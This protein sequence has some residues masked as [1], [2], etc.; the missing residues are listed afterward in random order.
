[1]LG[2][3]SSLTYSVFIHLFALSLSFSLTSSSISHSLT[4]SVLSLPFSFSFSVALFPSHTLSFSLLSPSPQTVTLCFIRSRCWQLR[5]IEYNM[6][7]VWEKT[8]LI[9]KQIAARAKAF[10]FSG[11]WTLGTSHRVQSGPGYFLLAGYCYKSIATGY[12]LPC[13]CLSVNVP[14]TRHLGFPQEAL[15]LE[16]E[17]N[18]FL[19]RLNTRHVPLF[20]SMCESYYLVSFSCRRAEFLC[21]SVLFQPPPPPLQ[22]LDSHG[23]LLQSKS[24]HMCA[25]RGSP[26]Y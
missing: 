22:S 23:R 16:K 12:C 24:I 26:S 11:L 19:Y 4:F 7:Q 15:R 3:L 6:P 13:L 5:E 10:I 21:P 17:W 8:G 18:C 1:M 9:V 2:H 20:D 25:E 14:Y